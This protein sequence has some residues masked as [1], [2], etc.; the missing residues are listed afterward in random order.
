[1]RCIN[2]YKPILSVYSN[3]IVRTVN[4]NKSVNSKIVSPVN[5]IKPVCP[6][7]SSKLL[8]PIDACKS[9][10]PV[11]SNKPVYPV[12]VCK[13]VGPV[14]VRKPVCLADVHKSF[15]VHYWGHVSSFLIFFFFF[16]DSISTSVF[17]RTILYMILFINIH[18]TYLIFTKFFNY[19][20]F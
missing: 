16:S 1:M 11:N 13:S 19:K 14:D 7:S 9:V 20:L 18:A 10:R 2:V 15:F 4:S 17:N 6:V 3:N 8:R 12:D 5:S